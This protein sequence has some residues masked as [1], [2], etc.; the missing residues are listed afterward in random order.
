VGASSFTRKSTGAG[1]AVKAI[2]EALGGVYIEMVAGFGSSEG[3]L[4]ILEKAGSVPVLYYF[5]ELE[6]LFR[7]TAATGSAG[8]TPLHMLY[9]SNH[10][11]HPL[12]KDTITVDDGYLGVLANSTLERFST[13]WQAENIDSGFFSRWMLVAGTP[14]TRLSDPPEPDRKLVEDFYRSLKSLL[15]VVRSKAQPKLL[16]AFADDGARSA[17]DSYYMDEIDTSDAIYNRIDTIGERLMTILT[18]AQGS[19]EIDAATVEAVIEFLRYEVAVRRRLRPVVANNPVA[20]LQAKIMALLPNEGD[21][22]KKRELYRKVHAEREGS[23]IWS[24]AVKGLLDQRDLK[25]ENGTVT[26]LA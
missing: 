12:R 16:V 7:K 14:R 18:L 4:R 23:E 6:L 22:M 25:Q 1:F 26:R 24:R 21:C 19:F 9:E 5:D 13:L 15:D 11:D 20:A 3:L 17:W 8:I 2:R 10:Y